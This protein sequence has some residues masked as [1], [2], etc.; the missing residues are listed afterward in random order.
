M[1]AV[2]I[3][4]GVLCFLLFLCWGELHEMNMREKRRLERL[5]TEMDR[6]EWQILREIESHSEAAE[7]HG[8]E[9]ARS[10][11]GPQLSEARRQRRRAQLLYEF[12]HGEAAGQGVQHHEWKEHLRNV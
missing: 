8:L 1:I 2:E 11:H 10:V 4:L 6:L 9:Y 5:L 12:W 3:G 7:E